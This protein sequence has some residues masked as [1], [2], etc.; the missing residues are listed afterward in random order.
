MFTLLQ[1]EAPATSASRP[2]RPS[3]TLTQS[4]LPNSD[5]YPAPHSVVSLHIQ[6]P[7]QNRQ[8]ANQPEPIKIRLRRSLR[9]TAPT[10]Q[11]GS[12]QSNLELRRH[13]A[14]VRKTAEVFSQSTTCESISFHKSKT[15]ARAC[16]CDTKQVFDGPFGELIRETGS[17][18]G[19]FNFRFSTKYQDA[20]TDLLYYGF[21][22]YDPVTG[23]WPS[24][25]PIGEAG[26]LNLYGFVG[27]DPVNDADYLGLDFIAVGRRGAKVVLSAASHLSVEF[28]EETTDCIREGYE[29]DPS[30]VGSGILRQA[31]RIAQYE[32]IPTFIDYFKERRTRFGSFYTPVGISFIYPSSEPDRVLV[33]YADELNSNA[34][35]SRSAANQWQRIVSDAT[36]YAYAEHGSIGDPLSNW[37]NSKYQLPPGNNSN[38]YIYELLAIIGRTQMVVNA[39][40]NAF[41]GRSASAV[42]DNSPTPIYR[43]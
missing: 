23:R 37:P 11:N 8:P 33:V 7:R 6:R 30:D 16:T 34:P 28:Y 4:L 43:P 19:E 24:R 40:P 36:S 14:T 26:G 21:R 9:N 27:N 20:E 15:Q 13:Q 1:Y 35:A 42:N 2:I 25:D 38:T 32:L 18:A 41:G 10:T 29:F 31:T 17:K 22:Y 3:N 39:F 12:F 5:D